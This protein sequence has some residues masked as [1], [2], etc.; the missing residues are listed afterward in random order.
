LG[1]KA[2]LESRP[3]IYEIVPPRRDPSRFSTEIGGV[4]G[5]LLDGRIAA[6]NIP[7]LVKRRDDHGSVVY[8]PATIPPEEYAMMIRDYKESVVNLVAPRMEEEA[9]L[10]R[11]RKI[12]H[13]YNVPNLV[14]VGKERT[15]D[16]LPGPDVARA[17]SLLSQEEVDSVA[18]GGVCIFSRT[19][20]SLDERRGPSS[21]SE[22]RRVWLK[23]QAG[24]DFVTSQINLEAAPVIRFLRAYQ[25]ICEETGRKPVTVFVSL[26]TVPTR[27]ILSLIESLD[28]VVPP[29]VKRRLL[30]ASEMGKESVKVSHDVFAEVLSQVEKE[31]ITVPLGLQ[32]EQVGVNSGA[33]TLDLLDSVYPL[34]RGR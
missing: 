10:A 27:T 2:L 31:G 25:A 17:L 8:S 11:A 21:Q 22:A 30:G 14:V 9:F 15:T 28:V 19:T 20:P 3:V 26:T 18:L 12:I 16:R 23:A 34:F 6:I 7:E 24:A 32:V 29:P 5:V 4:E 33:L 13:E 1:L